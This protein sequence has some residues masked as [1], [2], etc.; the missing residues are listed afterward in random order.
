MKQHM[1]NNGVWNQEKH[2]H[3][4]DWWKKMLKS[5]VEKKGVRFSLFHIL[6][7]VIMM[8][9]GQ[10]AQDFQKFL[11]HLL[12]YLSLILEPKA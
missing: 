3:N 7:V 6:I 5:A 8:S 10:S 11:N 1:N 9:S 12:P 4:W 2:K